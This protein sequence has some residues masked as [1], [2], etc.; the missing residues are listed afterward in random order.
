MPGTA[1]SLRDFGVFLAS[2]KTTLKNRMDGAQ[3]KE[4]EC[5]DKAVELVKEMVEE[6]AQNIEKRQRDI[7]GGKK[8]K[9]KK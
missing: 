9:S 6:Q 7:S 5:A 3:Y 2:Q 8:R 1:E 4:M